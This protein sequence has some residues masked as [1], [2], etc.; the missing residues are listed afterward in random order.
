MVLNTTKPKTN[1]YII[2]SLLALTL[3]FV[4]AVNS[5]HTTITNGHSLVKKAYGYCSG[6]SFCTS[7]DTCGD[8]GSCQ[9]RDDAYKRDFGK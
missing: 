8:Y 3:F 7:S 9:R 2:V 1:I 6:S 5:G 4:D